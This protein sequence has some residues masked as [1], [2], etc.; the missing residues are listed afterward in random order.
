MNVELGAGAAARDGWVALDLNPKNA[1]VIGD[2]LHL[3]FASASIDAL[4]AVDCLEHL[5]YRVT[6]AALDE[7]ARVLKPGGELFCQVPDAAEIMHWFATGDPRLCRADVGRCDALYGAQWRLLGGHADGVYVD[8][9]ADFRW[10]AHFSL[11]SE[12]A[13]GA[14]LTSAGFDVISIVTNAH[15]NL[16]ATARREGDPAP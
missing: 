15:P 16:L 4:R 1:A 12:G 6:D 14:A 5:S 13:L 9:D 8:A 3:P 2:A 10:N 7:W 11:W